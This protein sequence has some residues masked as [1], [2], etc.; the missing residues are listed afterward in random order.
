MQ[1]QAASPRFRL[2]GYEGGL[3]KQEI[4]LSDADIEWT[5]EVANTKAEWK[6]FQGVENPNAPRRNQK[7]SDP[8]SLQITPK[9][10]KLNGPND[11]ALLDDGTFLRESVYLGEVQTQADGRL[12]VLG[13]VGKSGP[14]GEKIDGLNSDGWYDDVSD[15]PVRASVRLKGT[16]VWIQASP[17]WVICAP[18]KF[19]PAMQH[20]ITLYDTL[21]HVAVNR[22]VNGATDLLPS[23]PPSFS[24]D[25]YPLLI[26]SMNM[27]WVSSS[28]SPM[29]I[30]FASVMTPPGSQ[31]D[32]QAIFE[33]LRNPATE[34][35][36]EI[37]RDDDG[38][39]EDMPKIWSD[40]YP[41]RDAFNRLPITQ[42]LTDI[43]YR[44]LEHWK[45][46]N[47]DWKDWNGPPV[48]DTQITPE[49]LTQAALESC[50]GG[51]FYPGIET[52]FLT[53]DE[54]P[55]IEP[56][57]LDQ[58]QVVPSTGKPLT[59]GDLT[60]QMAVP[61][62]GDFYE[63]DVDRGIH[64]WPAGRPEQVFPASGSHRA[65]VDARH[66]QQRTRDG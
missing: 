35:D 54:Y 27:K 9:A 22:N 6:Q 51:N 41:K 31:E 63:C 37:K 43:Q 64:W 16:N 57:R 3:L 19:T 60:K 5:V 46:G 55:F 38:T 47:F 24:K 13:G 48:P 66:Y 25:I 29:H 32:R 65:V 18:P 10:R 34:D 39:K 20:V 2:F 15:G 14:G 30:K 59:A 26:R 17:A 12:V 33:R 11:K 50:V 23:D 7:V 4:T 52:S 21:L 42:K 58:S 44:V 49:G 53:R 62:Q 28:A 56:F 8:A 40:Y 1:N 36:R 45:D 61:W